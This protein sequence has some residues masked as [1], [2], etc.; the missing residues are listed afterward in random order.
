MSIHPSAMIDPSA[1]IAD[2]VTIGPYAIVGPKCR[3]GEGSVLSAHAVLESHTILG[4]N[5]RVSPG[6]VLGGAPQD[7]KFK[8]EESWVIVGDNATIRECVT[9]NRASG[10]GEATR[11]GEGSLLM[12]YA[13]LG[14]NCQVG[15]EVVIANSAQL[16]GYVEVGD[17]AFISSTTVFH[18]FIHIGRLAIIG[19]ASGSRQDIPPFSMCN[20][21]PAEIVGI[22]KIGLRR[23]GVDLNART[24]IK[25]AYQLLW[26]SGLNTTQAIEAIRNELGSDP[27]VDELVT[28]VQNS[29]RGIRKPPSRKRTPG[30]EDPLEAADLAE[31]F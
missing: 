22:N 8:G 30:A 20:G 10:E 19:G 3:V 29:K 6:A 23:R 16:A 25:R 13:H 21:L 5:C 4:K 14:H 17:Y 26:F 18:Q 31:V 24:R 7:L 15:N 11:L 9:I 12:A 2:G 28:F 1:E 27:Y